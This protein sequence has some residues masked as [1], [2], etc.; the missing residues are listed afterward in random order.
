ML[1]AVIGDIVGSR[2]E[3]QNIKNKEF[4]LFAPSCSITDDSVMT[5]AVAQA[6]LDC[7]GGREDLGASAVRRMQNFGRRW[8]R[9]CYGGSFARWL[10]SDEPRP[11][12]S[13]G[14]GAAMRV[15]ACAWAASS[16][17]EA[18]DMARR[19]TAVT[20][21]HPEGL[22]GAA[23]IT[24]AIW[25]AREGED[26]AAL[27]SFLERHFYRLDFTLDQIRPNYG[28]DMSCQGSV[29]QA[30]TAFLESTDFEDAL[31][32]A[33]S[34]GGDSDTIAAIAGSV[35]EAFYGIPRALRV[36]AL[37]CLDD[38]LKTVV[39]DFEARFPARILD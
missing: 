37:A 34:L 13:Y 29:P 28:F 32:N 10:M 38:A 7:E 19:V 16:L 3:W 12:G 30:L 5:L 39:D 36:E 24:A 25:L 18:L 11:Y 4:A 33:V 9:G 1:G 15:S 31:R 26:R 2:F 21:D 27:R 35:A 22:K 14:N 23:A 6:I 8:A 20:H 17:D